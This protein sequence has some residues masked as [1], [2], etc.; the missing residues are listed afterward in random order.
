MVGVAMVVEVEVG[1]GLV[2]RIQSITEGLVG[3]VVRLALTDQV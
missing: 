3:Q 1:Q 2:G